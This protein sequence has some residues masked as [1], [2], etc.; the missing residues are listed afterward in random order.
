MVRSIA[1]L[2]NHLLIHSALALYKVIL[3]TFVCVSGFAALGGAGASHDDE[4]YG[5]ENFH[6][7]FKEISKTTPY[8][9]ASALLAVLFAYRG[10]FVASILRVL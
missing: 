8:S 7:S 10:W 9:Y 1:R 4:D 6:N 5:T 3:L 2:L